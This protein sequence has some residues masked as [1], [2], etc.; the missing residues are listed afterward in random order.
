MTR[1]ATKPRLLGPI[2]PIFW[3]RLWC[4]L[5]LLQHTNRQPPILTFYMSFGYFIFMTAL[6]VSWLKVNV[7]IIWFLKPKRGLIDK[8]FGEF[9]YKCHQLRN[10]P[11]I[12]YIDNFDRWLRL[13]M[14]SNLTL[15]HCTLSV[16][17][18]W[19]IDLANGSEP[20]LMPVGNVHI[21]RKRKMDD[22]C[23]DLCH[24]HE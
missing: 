18:S 15:W 20:A 9:Q 8:D 4:E 19:D 1:P 3:L 12:V 23:P 7:N 5:G 16:T 2:T 10:P 13:L 21:P 24:I 6:N 14:D 11:I 22:R 17:F